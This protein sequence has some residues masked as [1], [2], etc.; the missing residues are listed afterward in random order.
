MTRLLILLL[1]SGWLPIQAQNKTIIQSTEYSDPYISGVIN[2]RLK[3]E[4]SNGNQFPE[5]LQQFFSKHGG[6]ELARKFPLAKSPA[7][8]YNNRGERLADLTKLYR[9]EFPEN[10]SIPKIIK[11]LKS[12]KEIE[13]A[14]PHFVPSLCY[15]PNDTR[16]SEQYALSKIN[17]FAAWDLFQ[18]DTT[19]TIGI[20]DTGYDPFH[21]DISANIQK[22]YA[23]PINGID[24]DNDGYVDNFMGWDTGNNDSN[25]TADGNYHGQHV[26]GLSSASTDNATGVAGTGYK[27]RFIHVKVANSAGQL[28]GAYEGVVYAADHGCK[29]INCSWGGNQYSEVNAEIIRYA[30]INMDC[31]VF[32]GA[33]N[34]NNEE[35]FYP[36]MYPYAMSVGSTN[37]QDFKSDFS[38]YGVGIDIFAPG[39]MVLSTWSNGEYLSTGGT[40]MSSPIAAGCATLLRSAFPS[41]SGQQI[42]EQL[43]VTCDQVDNIPFNLPYFGKMGT[44]RINLFRALSETGR[45]SIVL[46]EVTLSD[47]SENLFLPGDTIRLSGMLINYLSNANNVNL[48]FTSNNP[49]IQILNPNRSLGAMNS[50]QVIDFNPNPILLVIGQNVSINELVSIQMQSNADDFIQN[51]FFNF[52]V[53]ADFINVDNNLIQTSIGGN[54]LVGVTGSDL[55]KGLGFQFRNSGNLLYQGGLMLGKSTEEVLDNVRAETIDDSDWKTTNQLLQIP[56]SIPSVEMYQ[57]R[58]HSDNIPSFQVESGVRVLSDEIAPNDHFVIVEY[59]FN[60]ATASNYDQ[61][62]AGIFTDWDLADYATNRAGFQSTLKLGYVYTAPIDS[63]YAG[64]QVLSNVPAMHHAMENVSGGVGGVNLG[65]GFS[66]SEKYFSLTNAQNEAGT[67]GNGNDIVNVVSAGP[68]SLLA[69]E[70]QVIAFAL[71]AGNN[72]NELTQAAVDARNFYQNTGGPLSIN[73]IQDAWSVFPNPASEEIFIQL[74]D[75]KFGNASIKLLDLSGRIILQ[76]TWNGNGFKLDIAHLKA[77]S[78]VLVIESKNEILRKKIIINNHRN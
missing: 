58:M 43:K 78:Y 40:S 11:A 1:L 56:V 25:P 52:P 15:V 14:E 16:I 71:L 48:V 21:P 44:G 33:G 8:K 29:V 68:F 5:N 54:S 63:I 3:N 13:F 46:N 41:M 2:F 75:K 53:F 59:T 62:Y 76:N 67:S 57:G 23:D 9:I 66:N 39:D 19:T 73:T 18:G 12:F 35:L 42:S 61:V 69:G 34:N 60:N 27:C 10:T 65:D 49:N 31:A 55:L 4:Y 36:A 38:N 64:V 28:T 24:D 45:A 77:G 17:A 51:Q 30:A 22:N 50:L 74:K 37:D 72:L 47:G 70:D 32:C 7:S 20:T 6:F 26:S